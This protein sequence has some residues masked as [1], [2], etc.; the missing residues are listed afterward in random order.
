MFCVF[1]G[2]L[3]SFSQSSCCGCSRIKQGT[4]LEPALTAIKIK[5]KDERKWF[6]VPS[7]K[8]ETSSI[9]T[10][11]VEKKEDLPTSSETLVQN[12][13]LCSLPMAVVNSHSELS[14]LLAT[15]SLNIQLNC[16]AFSLAS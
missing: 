13:F 15:C 5:R 8:E 1:A 9:T 3:D 16:W 4:N 6:K 14:D 7:K 10:P 12:M 11:E 2:G